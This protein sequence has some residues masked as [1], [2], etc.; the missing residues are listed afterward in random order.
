MWFRE[1][2]KDTV[3]HDEERYRFIKE[4]VQPQRR[5]QIQKWVKYFGLLFAAALFFGVTAGSVIVLLQ[6]RFVKQDETAVNAV[7]T[8]APDG[9]A[10]VPDSISE[11]QGGQGTS[12]SKIDGTSKR[13]AA[14]GNNVK[15]SLVGIS[16]KSGVQDWIVSRKSVEMV[17]YGII[18]QE[19]KTFYYILT[20]K[21][22]V[23]GHS[24]VTVQ[25]MDDTTVEGTVLGSDVQMDLAMVRISRREIKTK[26]SS[27][28]KV[29]KTGDSSW[30][31]N[32]TNVIA[33]GCPNGVLNSVIAGRI[34]NDSV[35]A[36]I[37]D[38]EIRLFCTDIPYSQEGN[39]VVLNTSGQ[40]VGVI[41][42]AFTEKTGTAGLAFIR[43][44][45]IQNLIELLKKKKSVPYLGIEGS[46]LTTAV[47]ETHQLMSGAY[48]TEVYYGSPAYASGMRA[49][50]VITMIDSDRIFGMMCRPPF[51]FPRAYTNPRRC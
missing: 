4:Q 26:V 2:D 42:T 15:Y 6:N 8:P 17:G 47:A 19:T 32:G 14:L 3:Y 51:L 10:G 37:T 35:S 31:T 29:A 11:N 13:L 45:D 50:D 23:K 44:S 39:G 18:I 16:Q 30:L 20:Q 49:A 38:G 43:I 9:T 41:A 34:I 33:V 24:K 27:Q 48:V 21:Q 40:V 7:Y 46:S 25:L 12:F 36:G 22:I 5:L 28:M 1:K